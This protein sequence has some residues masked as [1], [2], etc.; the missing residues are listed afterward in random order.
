MVEDPL[1]S[2]ERGICINNNKKITYIEYNHI[3]V[4]NIES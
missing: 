4:R 2:E 3:P 1:C